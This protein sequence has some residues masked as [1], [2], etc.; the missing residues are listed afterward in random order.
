VTFPRSDGREW[1]RLGLAY[2]VVPAAV[3][4][5]VLAPV[6]ETPRVLPL[7]TND[8]PVHTFIE[9]TRVLRHLWDTGR[10]LKMNVFA[11]FGTPTLGEPV[12]CPFAPHAVTYLFA[13]PEYAMVINEAVLAAL[14]VAVLTAFFAGYVPLGIASLCAVLAFTDPA[15]YYFFY[16]HPHQGALLYFA[17]ALIATRRAAEGRPHAG[18]LAFLAFLAFFLGVGVNGVLFGLPFLLGFAVFS[19]AGSG[20]GL[21][22]VLLAAGLAALAVHAH[23]V[24]FFRLA[25][26]SARWAS[27]YATAAQ[28]APPAAV[29]RGL[30]M[31]SPGVNPGGGDAFYSVPVALC[32]VLGAAALLAAA[33]GV[34]RRP[35]R[36][37]CATVLGLG[38]LPAAFVVGC[39]THAEA[40]AA[41]PGLR[42]VNIVRLLWFADVFVLVAAGVGLTH[43]WAARPRRRPWIAAGAAML[44]GA[45]LWPRWEFAIWQA[46]RHG[47]EWSFD[48]FRVRTLAALLPNTRLAVDVDPSSE[49]VA[50]D[51]WR[52]SARGVLGATGRSIILDRPF[53]EY[54]LSEGLASIRTPTTYAFV[55][56]PPARLAPLGVRWLVTRDGAR[57]AESFGWQPRLEEDRFVLFENPQPVTPAYVDAKAPAF[58][59]LSVDGDTVSVDLPPARPAGDVV[60]TLLYRPGWKASLDGRPAPIRAGR[61]DFMRITADGARSLRLVYEPFSDAYLWGSLFMSLVLAAWTLRDRR[62]AA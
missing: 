51:E 37:L 62:A 55:P 8:E 26:R 38:F 30:L 60:V 42:S 47:L 17:A 7:E 39:L 20:K 4:L 14:S 32:A 48:P 27:V 13:R 40:M 31:Y 6:F 11:N 54:L 29:L 24:E 36:V 35:D 18:R 49:G 9:A 19:C 61:D 3:A 21:R 50:H 33:C 2:V 10:F 52:A 56:N 1:R 41:T 45:G 22:T 34:G 43:L 23:Y 58:L 53:Q 15:F 5:F 57:A 25:A 16:N 46:H 59:D 12:L 28:A 44:L